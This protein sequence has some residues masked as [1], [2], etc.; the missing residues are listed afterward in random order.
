MSQSNRVIGRGLPSRVKVIATAAIIVVLAMSF[1]VYFIYQ[2]QNERQIRNAIFEQ[3]KERQAA[4]V[5]SV[6]NNISSD[7]D[8]LMQELRAIAV[9]KPIQDRLITGDKANAFLKQFYDES[10]V[11]VKIDGVSIIDQN[12]KVVNAYVG[13]KDSPSL[14]GLDASKFPAATETKNNL[15][16]PTFSTAYKSPIDGA[17]R[18]ALSYPVYNYGTREYMGSANLVLDAHSFL[19]KYGNLDDPN[20]QYVSFLD[21]N[22]TVVSSPFKENVGHN[23]NDPIPA[24]GSNEQIKAH[25]AKVLSGQSS[26]ALFNYKNGDR[27]NAGEPIVLGG[28]PTYFLFV[29]TPT[30][31]IYAQINSIIAS[32]RI[33]FYLLQ[34]AI[35]GAIGISLFFLLR[36]SGTL[37]KA[38]KERTSELQISNAKL[39]AAT[40]KLREANMQ[41]KAHDK[42]Q[43][44]FVNIAAHELRTPIQPI[45]GMTDILKERLGRSGGSGSSSGRG[46]SND[47]KKVV[48]LTEEQLALIDR[49]ARRLQK[50]SSEILDATRIEAGTLKLDLEEV[51]INKTISEVIADSKSLIP[52]SNDLVIQFK[53]KTDATTGNVIPLPVMVDKLRMFQVISNLIRNAIKFSG[54]TGNIIIVTA[55]RM[56][57]AADDD[58]NADQQLQISIKDQGSGISAE[59]L[60][61]LFTKF[62]PDKEK[63]GTGLGLFIAKNIVEAHGGR[64]WA[65]NN[66][67]G[68]GATF[69][70]TLPIKPR[71]M[72]T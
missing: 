53:P 59:M 9:S 11:Y 4:Y 63:G 21:K 33:S 32:Q 12:A 56:T 60:P 35:A 54:S 16:N 68:R 38:V 42:M 66:K 6:A 23:F 72:E 41:L 61:R 70:F 39:V 58:D 30:D 15:P 31:A 2:V 28:K 19:S 62:S 20:S 64:I 48:E 10:S 26:V 47:S 17:L 44:E 14:I 18:I 57:A 51:D 8:S 3:Q 1:I 67:D 71:N 65:E 34:G 40:E 22:W 49:N 46:K 27:L 7:L 29:T 55:E 25:F 36:W 5:K 37:E 50:L 24:K 69:T 52:N 45:I 13:I 43:T